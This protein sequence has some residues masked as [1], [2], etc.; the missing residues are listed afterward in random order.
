MVTKMSLE[1]AY[2]VSKSRSVSDSHRRALKVLLKEIQ[3]SVHQDASGSHKIKSAL[4]FV[5]KH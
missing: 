1:T 3:E 2:D 5:F 4:G